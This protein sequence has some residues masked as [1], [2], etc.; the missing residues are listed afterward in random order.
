MTIAVDGS[1]IYK[2]WLPSPVSY[3]AGSDTVDFY[4]PDSASAGVSGPKLTVR[5]LST[6]KPGTYACLGAKSMDNSMLVSPGAAK[7]LGGVSWGAVHLAENDDC[8]GLPDTTP[9]G[10]GSSYEVSE[11]WIRIDKSQTSTAFELQGAAHIAGQALPGS[12]GAGHS[13]SLDS[14]FHVCDTG[15]GTAKL[16]PC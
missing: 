10:I 15:Q 11:F 16:G 6:V 4:F 14:A 8:L 7:T 12:S 9:A 5:A 3:D 1:Q 2:G 13:F